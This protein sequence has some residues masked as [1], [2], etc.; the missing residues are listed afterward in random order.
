MIV[1]ADTA[2]STISSVL[3][4]LKFFEISMAAFWFPTLLAELRHPEV[5]PEVSA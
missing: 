3:A 2:R 5:P 4:I 1:V